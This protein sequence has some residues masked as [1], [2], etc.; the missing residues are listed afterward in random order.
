VI[1]FLVFILRQKELGNTV[2]PSTKCS[3]GVAERSEQAN[4]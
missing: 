4:A 1:F 3:C 2:R